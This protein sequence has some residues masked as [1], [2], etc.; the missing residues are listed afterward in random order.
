MN[1]CQGLKLLFILNYFLHKIR[2]N[3]FNYTNCLIF[4]SIF[5]AWLNS[6]L[7]AHIKLLPTLAVRFL[8][9][10]HVKTIKYSLDKLQNGTSGIE[11][12]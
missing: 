11:G 12:E 5:F 10:K 2:G 7:T 8:H 6:H 9:L 3:S 4:M 1:Q